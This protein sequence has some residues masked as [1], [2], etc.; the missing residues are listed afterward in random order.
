LCVYVCVRV[1]AQAMTLLQ[2]LAERWHIASLPVADL[3][4]LLSEAGVPAMLALQL[5]DLRSAI[6]KEA[7][8]TIQAITQSVGPCVA[9][10][11]SVWLPAALAL[12]RVTKE[13]M[14]EAGW[15]AARAVL[16]CTP[17]P[18]IARAQLLQAAAPTA[19]HTL[20]RDSPQKAGEPSI[21]LA[22]KARPVAPATRCA[23][24]VLLWESWD[25]WTVTMQA[26]SGAHVFQE[27]CIL[28]SC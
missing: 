20:R 25:R 8:T 6:V 23:A 18:P 5:S 10:F 2:Q 19:W 9:P 21:A 24:M 11:A 28:R 12:T 13:V 1:F 17:L 14:A 22:A 26:S 4:T 15:T 27:H 7:A 16:S 3:V